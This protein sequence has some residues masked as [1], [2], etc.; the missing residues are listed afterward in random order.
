MTRIGI[1][2]ALLEPSSPRAEK[3]RPTSTPNEHD[4]YSQV[5]YKCV[6]SVQNCV[7]PPSIGPPERGGEVGRKFYF[8]RLIWFGNRHRYRLRAAQWKRYCIWR[9]SELFISWEYRSLNGNSILQ[10]CVRPPRRM[11]MVTV[12]RLHTHNCRCP[13]FKI[14]SDI[15]PREPRTMWR[16][17]TQ[18]ATPTS[19][20]LVFRA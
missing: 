20:G 12:V 10:S 17:R 5:G 2:T 18:I 11:A 19:D 14:V 6:S 16:G 15:L 1:K 9:P 7:R 3:L 13:V 4:Q 8:L